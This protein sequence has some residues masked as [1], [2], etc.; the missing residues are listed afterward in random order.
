MD[1]RFGLIPCYPGLKVFSSGLADLALF[2][3]SEYKH[4]MKIMPFVLEGLIEEKK[5]E[6]LIRMFINWNKMYHQSRQYKFTQSDLLQ[7]EKSIQIWAKKF[8][9]ILGPFTKREC[10][11]SKFHHW[12]H[13]TIETI[14]EYGNL[15][16]LSAE[17]YESLHKQY[18]KVPY[19]M[20]NKRNIDIQILQKVTQTLTLKNIYRHILLQNGRSKPKEDIGKFGKKYFTIPQHLLKSLID[21]YKHDEECTFEILDGLCHLVPA[22]NDY[23]DLM[24]V[25]EEDIK[26]SEIIFILYESFTLTN[27]E[28][29]RATNNY[30]NMPMFSNIAVYMDS[31]QKEFETFNG[32]C[33]AKL[34][35]IYNLIPVESINNLVHIVPQFDTTNSYYVNI[36][37]WIVN[38]PLIDHMTSEA[39]NPLKDKLSGQKRNESTTFSA[40]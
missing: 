34:T 21:I 18:I 26:K 11:F 5:N 36:F 40:M 3:A 13:H 8:I 37:L 10:R 25:F 6:S 16:G 19:R 15:N 31:E 9:D 7:F 24:S 22:M 14:K 4:M 20:S 32:Y 33:F 27:K 39:T 17:T 28:Q 12:I 2:M 30:Y 29:I 1:L 23:F 35:N 38:T